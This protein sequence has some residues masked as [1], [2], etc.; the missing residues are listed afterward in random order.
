MYDCLYIP[1][2]SISNTQALGLG[3]APLGPALNRRSCVLVL[4]KSVA[5][6][7]RVLIC[8]LV[9]DQRQ[10]QQQSPDT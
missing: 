2:C 6:G 1:L 8:K 10:Q 5:S 4:D 3:L 9:G 7:V